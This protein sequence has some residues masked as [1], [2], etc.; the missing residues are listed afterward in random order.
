MLWPGDLC[1]TLRG[2]ARTWWRELSV[3][4]HPVQ[5]SKNLSHQT[6]ARSHPEIFSNTSTLPAPLAQAGHQSSPQGLSKTL[7]HILKTRSRAWK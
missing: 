3:S 4:D 1:G 5:I 2:P 7:E 6:Q